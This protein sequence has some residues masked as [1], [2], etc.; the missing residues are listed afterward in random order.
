MPASS[1]RCGRRCPRRRPSRSGH[2]PR[3]PVCIFATTAPRSASPSTRRPRRRTSTRSWPW[4]RRRWT[5]RRRSRRRGR[6]SDDA[7]PSW[8]ARLTRRSPFL[9]HPVFHRHRS[10]TQIMRYLKRL[11]QKDIGLD[12]SMIPLGSCTMKLTAAA[13]IRPVSWPEFSPLH[14]FAPVEQAAGYQA[15]FRELE[16]S[17][18]AITGLAAV[19]L[20]PNS[21]A[22]GE[23]AGLL[24]IR[25]YQRARGASGRDVVLIPGLGAWHEPGQRR[26]GGSAGRR[27]GLRRAGQRRPRRP[28]PQGGHPP[29]HAVRADGDLSVD[30]RRVRGRHPRDLRSGACARGAGLHGRR[31]H[32]RA[33]GADQRRGDRR[34]CLSHQSAQDVRHPARRRRTG[35]GADRGGGAPGA[36]PAGAC[37]GAGGWPVGHSR[38]RR[39]ALGQRQRAAHLAWLHADARPGRHA[40][41]QRGGDS[42]RQLPHGA[43]RTALRRAVRRGQRPGGPRS[44]LRPA[45]VQAGRHQRARRGQASDGLWIPT[46]RPSRFPWPAP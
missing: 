24:V 4:P 41:R 19:S 21:G 30:P 35:H 20:Q 3:R 22:Q 37:G 15:L 10:E 31:Q 32:E 17:L 1:T 23:F 18:C 36:L 2:G 8:P 34:R 7:A 6:T 45:G 28:A 27:R 11:E 29:R 25:A 44:H 26:D 13:E 16:A 38:R 43:A 46:R 14:P 39:G 9:T 42:Q 5:V 33:G 40:A 12:V